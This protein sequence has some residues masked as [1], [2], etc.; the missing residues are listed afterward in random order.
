M[1]TREVTSYLPRIDAP[2]LQRMKGKLSR[3]LAVLAFGAIQW[4]WLLRSLSGGTRAEK[5]EL[6]G[7]LKL[8]GNALPNLGSWKADTGLLTLLVRH[9][10][11]H[12]PGLVVEFGMGASTL[13]L[14]RALQLHGGGRLISFDQHVDFVAATRDWLAEYGL[15]AELN[16]VP[17]RPAVG[18]PGLWYDHGALPDRIDLMLVDGP[19]WA[20]H[21]LT[22]GAAATLFDRIAPGG[23][24]MLDD[25]A[26]PGERLVARRWRRM[27]PDFAFTL[28]KTGTKGTLIGRKLG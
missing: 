26:R 9:I 10:A 18:W 7:R 13:V 8:P 3:K 20:V 6:L 19:P 2:G 5:R 17:L 22:R 24:I 23:T 15:R 12:R 28:M 27:R 1:T 4:P 11:A 14:A 16:A 21:P 25:G